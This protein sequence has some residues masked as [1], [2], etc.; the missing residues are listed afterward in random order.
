MNF[1]RLE[2]KNSMEQWSLI[3]S[4]ISVFSTIIGFVSIILKLGK[5]K[6]ESEAT[7]RELR[8]DVDQ[9]ARDI[10]CLGEKV[11]Q[12]Q[13]ENTRLITTVTSDL[14]WIKSNLND[15]KNE[16]SKKKKE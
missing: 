15:I 4:I 1:L 2:A 9:N 14:G 13:I 16:I 7:Q 8:K 10:N 12:M 11:N 6:G 5:E 3:V